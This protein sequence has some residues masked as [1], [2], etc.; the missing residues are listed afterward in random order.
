MPRIDRHHVSHGFHTVSG[1]VMEHKS[2]S[3]PSPKNSNGV[4]RALHDSNRIQS[5]GGLSLRHLQQ[6]RFGFFAG[7]EEVFE[8]LH[9]E[10]RGG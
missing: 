2:P 1:N 4:M 8:D 6:G 5:S 7:F 3:H 10:R 9:V